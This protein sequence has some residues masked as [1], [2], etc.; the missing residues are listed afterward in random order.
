[1]KINKMKS[2]L[3]SIPVPQPVRQPSPMKTINPLIVQLTADNG[4]EAFGLAVVPNEPYAKSLK[5]IVETLREI[6]IG[7]DVFRPAEAW[8]KLY[9]GTGWMGHNGYGGYGMYAI[10]AIDTALWSMRAKALGIPLC[11]LLGGYRERVPVYASHLLFLNWNLDELQ[12]DAASLVEQGFRAMKMRMG[13]KPI[14]VELERLKTVREAI[15]KD[16][17]ILIDATWS[18]TVSETIRI[19]R[20][21][22]EYNVYWLED[23]LASNDPDQ[24]AQV[25]NALDV[26]IVAGETYCTKYGFRELI[27]KRAADIIM[28]D[29][30]SVGGITQWMKVAVM[31]EAWNLPVVSHLFHDFSVHLV[32]AVPNGLI[33]EYLPWVDVIYQT[34][35]VVKD[36][37][38]E[39]PKIPGLGL[40][41][42]PEALKKYE[43]K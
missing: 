27:D 6:I 23:P 17:D 21:I 9:G 3:L 42:N 12:K 31:A 25:A 43:L 2:M 8:Q 34:P 26:P 5:V 16:V 22:E 18:W 10:A 33:I 37:Y 38:I 39:I 24:L 35:P 30:Q 29:L 40:E 15:G 4:L 28:V 7:Q 36:G 19:G 14:D 20:K 41:L 11:Q 13:D 1:M 32:A